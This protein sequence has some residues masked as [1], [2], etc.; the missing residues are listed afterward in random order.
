MSEKVL[1]ISLMKSDVI[2]LI[3]TLKYEGFDVQSTSDSANA[4]NTVLSYEPDLVLIDIML[5]MFSGFE[6]CKII[7]N[8]KY[9]KTLPVIIFSKKNDSYEIK[10]SFE[11][12]ASDFVKEPF[13]EGE[14]ILRIRKAIKDNQ[15][16]KA[17]AERLDN[18]QL[19]KFDNVIY[20][21]NILDSFL[22]KEIQ[23][24][25]RKG[26]DL[27]FLIVDVQWDIKEDAKASCMKDI[28]NQIIKSLREYDIISK[29]NDNKYGILLQD[30][31]SKE[32]EL[33]RGRLLDSI[34]KIVENVKNKPRINIAAYSNSVNES[35]TP[36]A[37]YGFTERALAKDIEL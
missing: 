11:A 32:H 8:N 37:I 2:L 18:E 25:L 14:V 9:T 35:I 17:L 5:P 31:S 13:N 3:D 28:G 6:L 20:P 10:R 30:T 34:E 15:T 23:K 16:I 19:S 27:T 33:I 12:G 22:N 36:E 7:K 4:L 29:Y 24:N 21:R 26:S 1:I